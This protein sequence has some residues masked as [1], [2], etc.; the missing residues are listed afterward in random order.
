MNIL[1]AESF[2][3]VDQFMKQDPSVLAGIMKPE[4]HPFRIYLKGSK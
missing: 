4:T 3:E 1:K 2:D